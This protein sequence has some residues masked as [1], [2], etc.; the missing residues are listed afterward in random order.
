M[1]A[2]DPGDGADSTLL[3]RRRGRESDEAQNGYNDERSAGC[4]HDLSSEMNGC[5]KSQREL[6]LLLR[7]V[8]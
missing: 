6:T 5:M 4:K 1:F 3:G 2:H 7:R 8:V